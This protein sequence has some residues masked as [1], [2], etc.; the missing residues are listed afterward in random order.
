MGAEESIQ[1]AGFNH[2]LKQPTTKMQ[3]EKVIEK[4]ILN[5]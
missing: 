4:K 2:I 1:K 3:P 5:I